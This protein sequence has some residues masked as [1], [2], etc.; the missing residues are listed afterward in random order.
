[1]LYYWINDRTETTTLR[2]SRGFCVTFDFNYHYCRIVSER[3]LPAGQSEVRRTFYYCYCYYY[4]YCRR[5]R[6]LIVSRTIN[7]VLTYRLFTSQF[8]VF[9][10]PPSPP[11][12]EFHGI[13]RIAHCI[14][15]SGTSKFQVLAGRICFQYFWRIDNTH[16]FILNWLSWVV[17]VCGVDTIF[18]MTD[19]RNSVCSISFK[20]KINIGPR[21]GFFTYTELRISHPFGFLYIYICYSYLGIYI[22]DIHGRSEHTS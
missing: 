7:I 3:L 1:M 4:F 2:N 8:N 21:N 6:L 12:P 16:Y 20:L 11:P 19:S 15:F 18:H 17:C 14:L 22:V 9:N 13:R 10:L 5:Q